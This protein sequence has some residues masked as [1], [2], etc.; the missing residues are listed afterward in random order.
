MQTSPKKQEHILALNTVLT[1]LDPLPL[2]DRKR[3]IAAASAF[4]FEQ[5]QSLEGPKGSGEQKNEIKGDIGHVIAK[6]GNLRPG[7]KAA[8]IANYLL[9]KKGVDDFK[10]EELKKLYVDI[11][12][13]PP[14]RMDMTLKGAFS[15][16]NKLFR[17][18]GRNSYGL[19]FHGKELAKQVTSSN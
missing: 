19:T 16:G 1:A 5:G 14:D 3:V 12:I 7:Q 9:A 15:K 10:L 4:L 13:T 6:N 18:T 11:G 17:A 2:E 8:V